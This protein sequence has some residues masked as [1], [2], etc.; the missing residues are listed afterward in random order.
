MDWLQLLFL[1]GPLASAQTS[2]SVSGTEEV[3][4]KDL[5]D[6][7]GG[8]ENACLS[9]EPGN[10]DPTS[11]PYPLSSH[12]TDPCWTLGLTWMHSDVG[13]SLSGLSFPTCEMRTLGLGLG[14]PPAHLLWDPPRGMRRL[15]HH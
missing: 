9:W 6:G 4:R 11:C 15:L 8:T 3:P 13:F 12:W 14:S 1:P 7:Q 5:S 10:L 2:T